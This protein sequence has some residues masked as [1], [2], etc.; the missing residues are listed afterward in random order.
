M[1]EPGCSSR[2]SGP[3]ERGSASSI[4]VWMR[5]N[6]LEHHKPDGETF[7]DQLAVI[8][9]AV[10]AGLDAVHVT[11]YANMDVATGPTD[12]Y[13]PHRVG[14]LASYAAQVRGAVDVPVIT[15][16]R[17]EPDEA[18]AVLA[19]GNAD[20]VAMG[21]K[22]LADPELPNKLAAGRVE[23]IR[24]C[25]YQYRCIGNI[26]V[27]ESLACV[28]NAAT[29]RE[30][31]AAIPPTTRPRRVLVVGGGAAG[32]ESARV[33]AEAGHRVELHEAATSLGGVL[34][35]IRGLDDVLDRHLAWIVGEV[36]RL[37]VDLHLGVAVDAETVDRTVF[38][39]A[40][41]ATGPTWTR[42][43]VG[44]YPSPVLTPPQLRAF[45]DGDTDVVR[46]RV[47]I[48][49]GGKPAL[50]IA[51]A[52]RARGHAVTIIEAGSVF[53][54]ELGLPGRW[55]MVADA[56]AAGTVLLGG[57]VV[58]SFHADGLDVSVARGG[59]P[60]P[61]RDG[62]LHG[63]G[64]RITCRGDGVPGGRDHDLRGRRRPGRRRLRRHHP[65]RRARRTR[66]RG[67]NPGYPPIGARPSVQSA[68]RA[69]PDSEVGFP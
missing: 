58:R 27:N 65:G 13:A 38:D 46:A 57:A 31:V 60:H 24:P 63:T 15:F 20:F 54:A 7:A 62:H 30:D 16:G 21:R 23:Q 48:L 34:D 55:R 17:F 61:G 11:A 49:G 18:E 66:P 41:V 51:T 28:A 2:S 44:T 3:S 4:P 26:F 1:D 35:R 68:A 42:P 10:P 39:A 6:A 9:R 56:Q 22:L 47:A 32:L 53:G 50:T 33:L 43:D 14:D 25:L 40:V 45:L 64:R 59:T 36:E 29:G 8:D 67:L 37:G 52:L 19:A 69:E 5:I 12:S